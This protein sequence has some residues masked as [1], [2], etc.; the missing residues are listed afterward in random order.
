[1]DFIIVFIIILFLFFFSL[2]FFLFK[3]VVLFSFC[4]LA[5]VFIIL[6]LVLILV[7]TILS[8]FCPLFLCFFFLD[9]FPYSYSLVKLNEFLDFNQHCPEASE[10]CEVGKTPPNV[11]TSRLGLSVRVLPTSTKPSTLSGSANWYQTCLKG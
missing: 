11:C 1:M 5:I 6:T 7:F 3:L 2:S 4:F 10:W 8:F 9:S